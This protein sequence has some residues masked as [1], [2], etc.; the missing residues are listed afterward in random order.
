[1]HDL[2][3]RTRRHTSPCPSAPPTAH[4]TTPRDHVACVS[5]PVPVYLFLFRLQFSF[6][7]LVPVP[8]PVLANS[9][10]LTSTS[11]VTSTLALLP[12]SCSVHMLG[13]SVWYQVRESDFDTRTMRQWWYDGMRWWAASRAIRVTDSRVFSETRCWCCPLLSLW[14]H[15]AY[16]H[17]TCAG[18]TGSSRKWSEVTASAPLT[19]L[20]RLRLLLALRLRCE[21]LERAARRF[22]SLPVSALSLP[23]CRLRSWIIE[24]SL[25]LSLVIDPSL[26]MHEL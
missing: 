6:R 10:E 22:R 9:L 1:M 7:F 11:A 19:L 8:V 18:V 4:L 12:P 5:V 20:L 3:C 15:D 2:V 16:S 21:R 14:L 25:V 13:L 24:P 26:I 23:R 17:N